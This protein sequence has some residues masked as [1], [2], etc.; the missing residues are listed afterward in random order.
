[1]KHDKHLTNLLNTGIQSTRSVSASSA[2]IQTKRAIILFCYQHWYHFLTTGTVSIKS[3][4]RIQF[5]IPVL[6]KE[7]KYS[8]TIV[9][10]LMP[11]FRS[12]ELPGVTYC[13][14]FSY[15]ALRHASI[16][17]YKHMNICS[18]LFKTNQS[19]LTKFGA[20]YLYMRM[21]RLHNSRA[22][23]PDSPPHMKPALY[24]N[25][26]LLNTGTF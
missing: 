2:K 19:I 26:I 8:I 23:Y 3:I 22:T 6:F 18:S 17:V 10:C 24:D 9:W 12:P 13:H 1:M 21:Y 7:M 25:I 5:F 14:W 11:F 15:V 20:Y 4:D 16:I